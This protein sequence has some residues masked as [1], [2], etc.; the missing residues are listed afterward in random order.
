[1]PLRATVCLF[2]VGVEAGA[3]EQLDDR[4]TLFVIIRKRRW[5]RSTWSKMPNSIAG[6]AIPTSRRRNR[7]MRR[8]HVATGSVHICWRRATTKDGII[9]SRSAGPRTIR[10]SLSSG[11]C[12]RTRQQRRT[13]PRPAGS[14][15]PGPLRSRDIRQP[16]R[17]PRQIRPMCA[18]RRTSRTAPMA[19][20]HV[21]C[22]SFQRP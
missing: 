6:H 7:Q 16:R 20:R 17:R 10:M 15:S 11:S 12:R 21:S 19:N 3:I 14:D 2:M 5:L 22:G 4:K 13:R 9:G 8:P 1:M 18:A